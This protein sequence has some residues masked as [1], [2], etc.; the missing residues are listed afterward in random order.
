MGAGLGGA[1]P[2]IAASCQGWLLAPDLEAQEI[3]QGPGL[4]GHSLAQQRGQWMGGL[5]PQLAGSISPL[6]LLAS[7]RGWVCPS[8]QMSLGLLA[9]AVQRAA[10]PWGRWE[11]DL[12]H[13]ITLSGPGQAA[14]RP[15]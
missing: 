12:V 8:L 1:Q 14:R 15:F 6:S 10:G 7:S 2:G 4:Q 11:V 9:G 5:W 3:P 13:L